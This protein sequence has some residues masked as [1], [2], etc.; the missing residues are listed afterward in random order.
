MAGRVALTATTWSMAGVVDDLRSGFLMML[1]GCSLQSLWLEVEVVREGQMPPLEEQE[2]GWLVRACLWAVVVV[3]LRAK[4]ESIHSIST[5]LAT[6]RSSRVEQG[7]ST[8]TTTLGLEAVTGGMEA[9]EEGLARR[10]AEVDRAITHHM[11]LDA[12]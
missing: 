10:Q 11:H 8:R 12:V 1:M 5:R 6:E 7:T 3:G 4:V 9:Q 2:V